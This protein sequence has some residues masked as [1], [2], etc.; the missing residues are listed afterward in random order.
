MNKQKLILLIT[1]LLI[2]YITNAQVGIFVG[3]GIGYGYH[4]HRGY[5]SRRNQPNLPPFKPYLSISAGYGF[6]NLDKYQL[7]S[8]YNYYPGSAS[9]TG[10]II[11]SVDYRFNRNMSLGL[12]VTHGTVSQPYYNYNGGSNA[13]TGS[14]NNWSFMLDMIN[15][16]P[17]ASNNIKPYLRTAIGVNSWQQNFTDNGGNNLNIPG[18]PSYLA[19]Q[20]SLGVN[21][22]IAGNIGIFLEAGY[23]KYILLGGLSFKF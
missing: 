3:P 18:V 19:Y 11:G 13:F 5:K 10:P 12:M 8:F 2:F 23:G 9:Q 21:F 7:P 20:A 22:K 4:V 14:L 6:P 17:V 1:S 16:M 15:Y